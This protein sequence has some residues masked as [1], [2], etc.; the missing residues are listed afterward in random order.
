MVREKKLKKLFYTLDFSFHFHILY[1]MNDQLYYS[2][3][4]WNALGDMD[5]AW[6]DFCDSCLEMRGLA[7]LSKAECGIKE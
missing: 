4:Y 6:A 5:Y 7:T 1:T 3:Q 2:T